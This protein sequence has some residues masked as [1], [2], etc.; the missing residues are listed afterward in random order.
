VPKPRR[1]TPPL[2]VLDE[3]QRYDVDEAARLL[4]L[5]RAQIYVDM[6]EGNLRF[7]KDGRRS[8]I[9]GSEIIRRSRL[10]TP[11]SGSPAAP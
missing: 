7:I 3:R 9:P 11:D 8:F 10:P 4:R 6:R 5:S 1:T 2:P